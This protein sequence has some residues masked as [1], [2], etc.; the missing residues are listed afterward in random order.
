[1]SVFNI[2]SSGL[3]VCFVRGNGH[4]RLYYNHHCLLGCIG[5]GHRK[6]RAKKPRAQQNKKAQ[7]S[8]DQ[9]PSKNIKTTN[10]PK[11]W[12][13]GMSKNGRIN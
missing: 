4:N 9:I 2:L 12:F 6:K 8:S 1:M 3:I 11:Q 10:N 5:I 13:T 7:I